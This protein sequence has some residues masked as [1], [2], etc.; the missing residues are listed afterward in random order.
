LQSTPVYTGVFN[1]S[2]LGGMERR[3]LFSFLVSSAFLNDFFDP[4]I[5]TTL[6]YS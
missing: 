3:F 4:L 2:Q 5:A 6:P 1:F